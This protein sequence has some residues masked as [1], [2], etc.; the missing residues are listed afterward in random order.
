MKTSETI[1]INRSQIKFAPYNPREEDADLVKELLK[2]F[3]NVGF[4]G[5][6]VWNKLS[7]NL[8]GGHKRV[9]AHDVYYKFDGT[10]DYQIKVESVELD[11]KTEKEQNIFLNKK[12]GKFDKIKLFD[13]LQDIDPIAAGYSKDEISMLEAMVPNVGDAFAETDI[14]KEMNE[15]IDFDKIQG[16]KDAKRQQSNN[17]FLKQVEM[18]NSL[19]VKF[20]SAEEKAFFCEMA[21]VD[22]N[23]NTIPGYVLIDIIEQ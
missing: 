17:A 9:M 6:V 13:L 21:K 1:T 20:E 7:G 2:N 19:I 22:F 18:N 12:Q 5:G 23:L 16:V 4:L 3:K 14:P 15:T 8:V 11:T 10:N